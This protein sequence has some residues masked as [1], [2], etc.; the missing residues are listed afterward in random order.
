MLNF[1]LY[2]LLKLVMIQI[3]PQFRLAISSNFEFNSK[4]DPAT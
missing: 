2:L 3:L 4:I 1:N